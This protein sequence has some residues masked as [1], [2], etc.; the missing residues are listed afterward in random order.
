V[1]R[2]RTFASARHASRQSN[3][4]RCSE[5]RRAQ[6]PPAPALQQKR[7]QAAHPHPG[8][9]MQTPPPLPR[10]RQPIRH[11]APVTIT[12]LNPHLVM[13]P[14]RHPRTLSPTCLLPR[15][16]LSLCPN[17]PT[18][19]GFPLQ[20]T[21][22]QPPAPNSWLNPA[23][24]ARRGEFSSQPPHLVHTRLAGGAGK[25]FDDGPLSVAFVA[26]RSLSR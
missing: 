26:S 25:Q 4:R 10:L 22:C 6:Q 21:P 3:S 5:V 23:L 14:R 18:T 12:R 9:R 1:S 7:R 11:Q 17:Q 16:P 8:R 2:R 24:R 13:N 20:P 15:M 19:R